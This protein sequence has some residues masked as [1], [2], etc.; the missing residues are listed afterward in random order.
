VSGNYE[1]IYSAFYDWTSEYTEEEQKKLFYG[2]AERY[3]KF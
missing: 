2:N 1:R 3:Y